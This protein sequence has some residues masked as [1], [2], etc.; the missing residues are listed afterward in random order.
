MFVALKDKVFINVPVTINVTPFSVDFENG[1]FCLL[2]NESII[3][4]NIR[5][6]SAPRYA[7][8]NTL[9]SDGT[10]VLELVMTHA[11]RVRISPVHGC[12]FHCSFCTSNAD[13]YKEISI[14]QLNDAFQI[15]LNDPYNKP[16]HVLI[17]GGTLQE[18]GKVI[19]GL[20]MYI[21]ISQIIIL[22]MNLT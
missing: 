3:P 8:E 19:N 14:D 6:I 2:F 11:D 15:A 4:L 16:R 7:L 20:I 22:I 5:I 1:S 12:S 21:I 9:L 18:E 13:Y 17:S 10:P